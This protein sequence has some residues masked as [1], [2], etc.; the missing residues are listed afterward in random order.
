MHRYRTHTCGALRAEHIGSTVRLSGWCHR[1][2]DHGGITQIVADSD[3]PALKTAKM[4]HAE[5]VVRF[6]GRVRQRPDGTENAELPTGAVEVFATDIEVLGPA[7]ELP[8]P[9]FGDQEYPE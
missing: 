3:S 8:M 1:I 5:W 7:G 4:L 2:R 9:V 6:D